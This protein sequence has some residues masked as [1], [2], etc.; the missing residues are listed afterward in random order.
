MAS[1]FSALAMLAP[2]LSL[3]LRACRAPWTMFFKAAWAMKLAKLWHVK[4][5]RPHGYG[6]TDGSCDEAAWVD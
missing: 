2:R 3:P 6:L 1:S 4:T 5:L